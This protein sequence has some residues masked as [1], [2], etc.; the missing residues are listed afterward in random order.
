MRMAYTY[1]LCVNIS[2]DISDLPYDY[3]YCYGNLTDC[4]VDFHRWDGKGH[5]EGNWIK[6]KGAFLE[7]LRNPDYEDV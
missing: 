3:R 1:A 7:D 6:R 4:L 5:P 2:T